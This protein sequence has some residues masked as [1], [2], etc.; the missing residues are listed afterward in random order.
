MESVV[1]GMLSRIYT[2]K[3]CRPIFETLQANS[4]KILPYFALFC[5]DLHKSVNS[6]QRLARFLLGF[7]LEIFKILCRPTKLACVNPVLG[8]LSILIISSLS[9][10]Y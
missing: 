2:R 10:K 5:S 6:L 9:A 1:L 7:C 8:S 4:G 3:L